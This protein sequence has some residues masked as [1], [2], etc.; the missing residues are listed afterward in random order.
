MICIAEVSILREKQIIQFK[1]CTRTN[2]YIL[3]PVAPFLAVYVQIERISAATVCPGSASLTHHSSQGLRKDY[4]LAKAT[5]KVLSNN[6]FSFMLSIAAVA[7]KN[8][9]NAMIA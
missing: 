4:C 6:I 2:L 5:L 7:S 3:H 1:E 9:S 8:S